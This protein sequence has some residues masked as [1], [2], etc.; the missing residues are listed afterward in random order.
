MTESYDGPNLAIRRLRTTLR[1]DDAGPRTPT[2]MRA[3]DPT[4]VAQVPLAPP[5]IAQVT[6][7]PR[8]V[9]RSDDAPGAAA[10][11][12]DG[13][14]TSSSF[15]SSSRST[16]SAGSPVGASISTEKSAY[17]RIG[18]EDARPR[19]EQKP[20]GCSEFEQPWARKAVGRRFGRIVHE[21]RQR[22][23]SVLAAGV[24]AKRGDER[25]VRRDPKRQPRIGRARGGADLSRRVV[26]N[27]ERPEGAAPRLPPQPSIAGPEDGRSSRPAEQ[28]RRGQRP[29]DWCAR[30]ERAVGIDDPDV[31]KTRGGGRRRRH[32]GERATPGEGRQRDCGAC[33]EYCSRAWWRSSRREKTIRAFRW[34]RRRRR[35]HRRPEL[36]PMRGEG[37]PARAAPLRAARP[38]RCVRCGSRGRRPPSK[39]AGA[40]PSTP[41]PPTR[42]VS[43]VARTTAPCPARP[44]PMSIGRC[45]SKPF[46]DGLYTSAVASTVP[47]SATPPATSAP[48]PNAVTLGAIRWV[49]RPTSTG[50]IVPAAKCATKVRGVGLPVPPATSTRPPLIGVSTAPVRWSIAVDSAHDASDGIR[51][52]STSPAVGTLASPAHACAP[53]V[54]RTTR[55]LASSSISGNCAPTSPSRCPVCDGVGSK[56]PSASNCA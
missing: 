31:L 15:P 20:G 1:A 16:I 34:G 56:S 48:S 36:R 28:R 23:R 54:A 52:T 25:S 51:S 49:S 39:R 38:A 32:D 6:F 22:Q 14:P 9:T 33:D 30:L 45:W 41:T 17:V 40:S 26:E 44:S 7:E 8:R 50:A 2:E 18:H 19:T 24:E 35:R 47:S 3:F 37:R 46:S 43:P 13:P 5:A 29:L 42:S 53:S 21:Q 12:Q 11:A 55:A 10:P 4:S 27:L